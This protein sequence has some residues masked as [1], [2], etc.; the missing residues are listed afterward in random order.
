M[1][2][3]YLS[4]LTFE[5]TYGRPL[6]QVDRETIEPRSAIARETAYFEANIAKV[7]TGKEL[8]RDDRLYQ[9]ALTAFGLTDQVNN[10]E[11][12]ENVLDQ[13]VFDPFTPFTREETLLG[14]DRNPINDLV[15][16]F[17]FAEDFI[18]PSLREDAIVESVDKITNQYAARF[19]GLTTT[20]VNEINY[21]TANITKVQS[22]EDLVA[23]DRLFRFV[24]N[25]Y[26]LADEY[27]N[28]ELIGKALD[29][30][31]YN[32]GAGIRKTGALANT[33]N[34]S[35]YDTFAR[36]FAFNELGD[37]NV[38]N[39]DFVKNVVARY[40]TEALEANA[41]AERDA[42]V[43]QNAF[44][45]EYEREITYFRETIGTI[46]NVEEFL[47]NDRLYRFA[48][49]AFDLESQTQY[50]GLI[51]KVLEEGVA[52]DKSLA[53]QLT[54]RKFRTFAAAF[55]FAET[56]DR[57]VRNPNFAND[58]IEQYQ[59]VRVE[60]DAGEDNIGVRLAAYFDRQAPGITSWFG[61][62]GDQALR[63]VVFTAFDLPDEMQQTNPD[64]LVS[65]FEQ[66]FDIEDFQDPE[67]LSKFIERF[68][69]LYDVKNGA[70]GGA[71]SSVLSLYGISS[72]ET[73]ASSG[74]ISIDPATL[75]ATF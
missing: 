15:R 25:A 2:T 5:R 35:R 53:N 30:G 43:S 6:G 73:T 60:T 68:T 59:R 33:V 26:G 7:S 66:R 52:D 14:R 24:L 65:I 40:E 49:I 27:G 61:F 4:Y 37:Q 10:K 45:S 41:K 9:Y 70:P 72:G 34:D 50:K 11:F 16:D 17:W 62:L 63:E 31:V 28:R 32:P 47:D 20:V 13:G 21:F 18:L 54:D 57:N 1:T 55:G 75:G 39:G 46:Y 36:A 29:A 48:L 38:R 3:T 58:V 56:G 42:G 67:K 8:V 19:G 44:R 22:G 74:L 23:D 71:G 69:V 64:K 12:I 51:R